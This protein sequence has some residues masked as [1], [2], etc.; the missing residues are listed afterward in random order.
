MAW[1]HVIALYETE[2]LNMVGRLPKLTSEHIYWT[3][4]SKMYVSLAA[5]LMSKAVVKWMVA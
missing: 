5:E 1:D 4:F 2:S 3:P